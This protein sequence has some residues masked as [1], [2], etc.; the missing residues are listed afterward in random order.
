[1][2]KIKKKDTLLDTPIGKFVMDNKAL[3]ILIILFILMAIGTNG[4]FTSG[5][6]LRNLIR[7]VAYSV[8]LSAGYTL[9]LS[10]GHI[11]LAVGCMVG[12]VGVILGK[13]L[14]AGVPIPVAV[15]GACVAGVACG[16][17]S[18]TIITAFDLPPFI[19]TLATMS[20]FK[21]AT[22]L[23]TKMVPVSNLPQE[24]I[25][26]GQGYWLGIPIPV[27]IMLGMVF[28]MVFILNKT[29]FGRYAL[30]MGGNP[31]AARLSGINIA[32]VRWGVY[33]VMGVYIAIAATVLTARSA[34]AQVAA[35]QNTELDAIAAVVIGG[36]PLS[37]GSANV[38]GTI[39][40][41]M[42][43]GVIN[44]G[45]NLLGVDSNWQLVAKGV[46]I[47]LAIILD[48]MSTKLADRMSK[49]KMA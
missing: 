25:V 23:V 14:V 46:M 16:T 22:Y 15:L 33:A 11:D 7:Q 29:K 17:I 37:G 43:V 13:F 44:N 39:F 20:A 48:V 32:R 12:L 3:V 38:V 31:E 30:A 42:I 47:L 21:G 28:I 27:Y 10:S 19:V 9:L 4:I 41:C 6:N 2:D 36:T 5:G 40:G 49:A 8:I 45:L 26:I 1:M 24:F 18:A 35:G 34:S